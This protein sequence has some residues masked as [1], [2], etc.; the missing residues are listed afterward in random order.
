VARPGT[1]LTLLSLLPNTEAPRRV[2]AAL[3]MPGNRA[4][5]IALSPPGG[6]AG[7]VRMRQPRAPRVI[8]PRREL[9]P[10]VPLGPG[11]DHIDIAPTALRAYKPLSPVENARLSAMLLGLSGG[12]RLELDVGY[13][14]DGSF[15]GPSA[16]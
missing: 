8:P 1:T 7:A 3:E 4:A 2:R 9:Y 15:P 5:S 6:E 13:R 10:T 11:R 14:T 16:I 12:V